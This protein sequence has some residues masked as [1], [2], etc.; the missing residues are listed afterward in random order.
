MPTGPQLERLVR[1][2]DRQLNTLEADAIRRLDTALLRA[3][4][5]LEDE[6]RAA[7]AASLAETASAGVALREARA[8]VLLEQVRA[9]LDIT[10]SAQAGTI[11]TTLNGGAY[12]A[13]IES[14]GRAHV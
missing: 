7:Y 5:R 12:E 3:L 4:R 2:L 8:R 9:L 10:S 6:V 11:L 14:I 13:G 1:R